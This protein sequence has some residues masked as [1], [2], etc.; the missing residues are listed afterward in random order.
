MSSE[1]TPGQPADLAAL[2]AAALAT[3]KQ[4][5]NATAA[6]L[7]A[8]PTSEPPP[9]PASGGLP[10]PAAAGFDLAMLETLMSRAIARSTESL[11]DGITAV[12]RENTVIIFRAKKI[13]QI[14]FI[15]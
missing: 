4:A 8:D 11:R 6:L 5:E 12:T 7:A 10:P 13:V 3:K 14:I 15:E 2:R 9:P 1:Q